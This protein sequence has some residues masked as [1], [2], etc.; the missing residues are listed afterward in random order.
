MAETIKYLLK[1]DR[2]KSV[3]VDAPLFS[4]ARFSGPDGKRTEMPRAEFD[5][6]YE[7]ALPKAQL[8]GPGQRIM[9]PGQSD[10]MLERI[11]GYLTAL[12]GRLDELSQKVDAIH[13]V[14]IG[15][16]KPSNSSED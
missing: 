12:G 16:E 13:R 14:A 10:E 6:L 4:M 5:A 9:S 8:A 2:T 3:N 11:F 1:S 15:P 7:P